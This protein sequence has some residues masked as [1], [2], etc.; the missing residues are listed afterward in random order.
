[1]RLGLN[2]DHIATLREARKIH[3]PDPLE[4]V[5][6]AKNAGVDLITL[7][8]RE[9]RRHI[10]EDDVKSIVKHAPL[11]INAECAI[12]PEITKILCTLKP[13]K[14]TLVP[15]RRAE[16]TTEGGL[17]LQHPKLQDT[18]KAYSD[19]GI[20]VAL[21]I[22]P[23]LENLERAWKL[24]VKVVELHTGKF[25]NVFNTLYTGFKHHK[26]HLDLPESNATLKNMLEQS[27]EE[28][29]QSALKGQE[30][31][32]EVCAGHGLN[33]ASVGLVARL[34]GIAELNIG[35]A[36]IARAVIV[37]L[38]KAIISMQEAICAP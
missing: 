30:M 37:G 32:L 35:H 27:L 2:I 13:F 28:L 22:D 23:N 24:G 8:L 16:I 11:P 15:E 20:E 17:N 33:Y 29:A 31:G 5:F 3:E 25:S 12:D 26:N 19:C 34:E 4:A 9:D 21:F 38:E 10:H 14:A 1:M 36:I 7:H 6:I 18:I